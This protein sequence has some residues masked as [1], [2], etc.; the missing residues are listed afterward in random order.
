MSAVLDLVSKY[1]PG[2]F[3]KSGDNNVLTRCPFHKGGQEKRPSFSINTEKGVYMCFTGGCPAGS[4]SIKKLLELLSVPGSKI[5]EHMTAIQPYLVQSKRNHELQNIKAFRNVDPFKAEYPLTPAIQGAYDFCPTSLLDKGFEQGLLK[6]MGVGYD[7]KHN[8]VMYPIHDMYGALV[9]FSGGVTPLT[10]DYLWQKY[11]VYTGKMQ[12]QKGKWLPGDYGEWFDDWFSGEYN[13]SSANYRVRNHDYLWNF[14]RVWERRCSNQAMSVIYVV[15]GFKACLWMLQA[16]Y[17]NTVALMGSYVSRRQQQM[18]QKTGCEIALCLDN[19]KAGRSA[20]V[21]VGKELYTPAYGRV[22]V[23]Q[24][25][26]EDSDTQPD[27]YEL[28][29]LKTL[30]DCRLKF[31]DHLAKLREEVNHGTHF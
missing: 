17:E 11:R 31:N 28:D 30:V 7:I 5:Q 8:R 21:E 1:L 4:G 26:P 20:T 24:Y 16:G 10:K 18:L 23:M 12:D 6:E 25:P 19:D 3:K 9:G 27:D 13:I 2:P 14:H 22:T 29:V 15:E